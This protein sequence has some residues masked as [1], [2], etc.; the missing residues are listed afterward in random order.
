[1]WFGKKQSTKNEK[2]RQGPPVPGKRSR[3][4]QDIPKAAWMPVAGI[5]AVALA[6][7]I[8]W[9]TGS[10]LFW[11]NPKFAIKT[12]SI[13]L[14][15]S[16]ITRTEIRDSIGVKEGQ[17]LFSFN[18]RKM[19][20][21]FLK[22]TPLAK[23]ISIHRQLPDTLVIKVQE[24]IP[25]AR[26]GR[27]SALASDIEGHT[28]KLRANNRDFPII[29][30]CAETNL[31][32]GIE[33]DQAVKNAILAIDACRQTRGTDMI[34]VASADVT[35][36]DSIELYLAAGE[37]IKVGWKDMSKI[38]DADIKELHEQIAHLANAMRASEERG[39]KI[40]NLD[41]TYGGQYVPAQ[42]Y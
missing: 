5:A 11:E 25:V 10:L 3:P 34:R 29:S 17:N 21:A 22:A 15:G 4:I 42:E 32:P 38:S 12:I 13:N 35:S 26:I 23:S 19:G 2:R 16:M 27:W 18:I 41:L 20:N 24:R 40:V 30:G 8:I 33:V 9:L 31:H 36:K 1:M 28:F 7:Y 37:R 6:G 14:E 39:K